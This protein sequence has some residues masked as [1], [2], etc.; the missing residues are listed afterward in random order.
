MRLGSARSVAEDRHAVIAPAVGIV[1][2]LVHLL[3]FLLYFDGRVQHGGDTPLY[4]ELAGGF[5]AGHGMT[6]SGRPSATYPPGYPIFMAIFAPGG[7]IGGL[8][9]GA[10]MV[11]SASMTAAVYSIARIRFG[12]RAALISSALM[13]L[14]PQ[15]PFWSA[16]ALSDTFGLAVG[17]W[18]VW[19]LNRAAA[20]GEGDW[21]SDRRRLALAGLG[22]VL[23]G[24]SALTRPL[25]VPALLF[26]GIGLQVFRIRRSDQPEGES[27][28]LGKKTTRAGAVVA[29]VAALGFL[30]PVGLWTL[31]NSVV[32]GSPIVLSSRTGWQLWQG[33]LWDS[34]GRGTV[35]KDVYYPEE[36]ASMNEVEADRYLFRKAI[37]EIRLNPRRYLGK[38]FAKV[39]Y[40]WSPTA[41]G[42]GTGM[43]VSGLFFCAVAALGAVA[44]RKKKYR[45]G[46]LP[47][48][49][50]ALGVTASVGFTILDPDY[51]YRL[52]LLVLL[53]I[54]AGAGFDVLAGRVG[55]LYSGGI[56]QGGSDDGDPDGEGL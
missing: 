15:V 43:L 19:A 31:R 24:V 28:L 13:I 49:L 54:P 52:P 50:G 53:I 25:N 29:A 20:P 27:E 22:G 6:L 55:R 39:L 40:L 5:F 10:Q 38:F 35:G 33:V 9:A 3:F 26:V 17:V 11:V 41:P 16:Y 51:R 12:A 8:L 23:I 7:R 18:G 1:S 46:A 14:A 47:F 34:H 32:M 2:F 21:I 4:V 44:L 30:V 45:P 37:D 48:W 36:A 56:A 42:L